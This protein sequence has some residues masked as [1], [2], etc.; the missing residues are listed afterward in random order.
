MNFRLT[1]TFSIFS[2]GLVAFW[3]RTAFIWVEVWVCFEI[4]SASV[5]TIPTRAR[6]RFAAIQIFPTI[7]ACNHV[8]TNGVNINTGFALFLKKDIPFTA[9]LN[10]NSFPCLTKLLV[11]YC[12]LLD[13]LN[14]CADNT[15]F[16]IKIH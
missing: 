14:K 7:V 2:F 12:E 4:F 3:A 9:Q 15:S 16:S 8:V 1:L 6:V 11:E 5:R 10:I 13:K